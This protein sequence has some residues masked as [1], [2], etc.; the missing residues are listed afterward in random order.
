MG[1][2]ME[3]HAHVSTDAQAIANE[4]SEYVY[5]VSHDLNAPV[6]AMVEFSKLLAADSKEALQGEPAQ[7]LSLI[8][9]NGKKLQKMMDGLLQFSRLNTMG[10]ASK[11]V[12]C[13]QL[14]RNCTLILREELRKSG[15]TIEIATLPTV[16]ADVDQLMQLL[17]ALMDNALKFCV[18]GQVPHIL[19]SAEQQHGEWCFAISDNGIGIDEM[20]HHRIFQLFQRLHR[21]EE[22]EGVGMGLTLAQKIVQRHGG[23]IWVESRAGEGSTFYFTLPHHKNGAGA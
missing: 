23:R 14:A 2:A 9:E 16:Q 8:V 11:S 20:Y 19:I 5:H 13:D 10:K 7:Y 3:P 1:I 6:R 18:A 4:F 15:G 12:D 21:D 17:L 22:Y